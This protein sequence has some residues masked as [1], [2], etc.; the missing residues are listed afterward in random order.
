MA[1]L[2]TPVQPLQETQ[3]PPQGHLTSQET[4]SQVIPTSTRVRQ[5]VGI[6]C[7]FKIDALLCS[8]IL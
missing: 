3:P 4:S 8:K 2:M 1:P 5:K 6:N 7:H